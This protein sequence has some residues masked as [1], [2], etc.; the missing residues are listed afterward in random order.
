M[1]KVA[2]ITT[3][4]SWKAGGVYEML[5]YLLPALNGSK[6]VTTRLFGYPEKGIALDAVDYIEI[7]PRVLPGFGYMPKMKGAVAAW[8]PDIVHSHGIWMYNSAVAASFA[9]KGGKTVLTPH[10]MLDPWVYGRNRWKKV[11]VEALFENEN[12]RRVSCIHALNMPEHAAIRKLGI[13]A[14][15]AVIPNGVSLP[16]GEHESAPWDD[17]VFPG[18]RVLLYLGRIHPKK[19]LE[20]LLK[21]WSLTAAARSEW[22]IV[23]AGWGDQRYCNQIIELIDSLGIGNSVHVIGPVFDHKKTGC[24]Q[25]ASAFILPSWSEGLPMAVLEAWANRLPVLMTE[26]CNLNAAFAK[27]AALQISHEPAALAKTLDDLLS[28]NMQ[29]DVIARNGQKL[30]EAHYQWSSVAMMEIQMYEWILGCAS[31]PSFIERA[32]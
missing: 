9:R 10:G 8:K 21:A 14:P 4:L 31:C 2:H 20:E 15:I 13:R 18:H 19:G 24:L 11:L 12:I 1:I 5:R 23:I 32:I 6:L 16:S 29:L 17:L 26:E 28:S 25:N 27:N 22:D 3:S 30:A 7:T